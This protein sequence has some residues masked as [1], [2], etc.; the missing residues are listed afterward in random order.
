[1]SAT[2]SD[3]VPI[4]SL[5]FRIK[6]RGVTYVDGKKTSHIFIEKHDLEQQVKEYIDEGRLTLDLEG[7]KRP[8]LIY[9]GGGGGFYAAILEDPEAKIATP[10]VDSSQVTRPHMQPVTN[11]DEDRNALRIIR[12]K[13][14]YDFLELLGSYRQ[15]VNDYKA[16]PRMKNTRTALLLDSSESM[17]E[18]WSLWEQYQKITIAQ[19]LAGVITLAQ[20]N[21][22]IHSV[23]AEI[24]HIHDASEVEPK[25]K[26]TR[27]D[28]ALGEVLLQEP[29]RVVVITDGKPVSIIG[30]DTETEN[31]KTVELLSS[32]A[33]SNLDV[34][35]V[36]L[37]DD[38]DMKRHYMQLEEEPGVQLI[39]LS[40]GGDFTKM[41]H[42]LASWLG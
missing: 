38:P 30:E 32:L 21:T 22:S 15:T 29:E 31:E 33:R 25:G 10:A 13:R 39:E 28:Q 1:M 6:G 34:L 23:G 40:T 11:Y 14:H 26:E 20:V 7:K 41:M 35:V 27:L 16:A 24:K 9:F 12:E 5:V 2:P 19:F 3:D 37:G 17:V 4:V 36:L 18:P 42:R 8:D